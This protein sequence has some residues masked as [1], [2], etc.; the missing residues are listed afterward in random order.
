MVVAER[1][2]IESG[3]A[4]RTPGGAKLSDM[5]NRRLVIATRPSELTCR[6]AQLVQQAID[7]T[8]AQA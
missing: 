8:V 6:Q 4:W 2:R 7:Q 1:E 5:P 3:W